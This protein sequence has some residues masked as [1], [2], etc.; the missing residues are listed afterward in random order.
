VKNFVT[1]HC[2][3]RSLDSASTP[4]QFAKRELELE[5]GHIVVTDH[6]TLEATRVVYDLTK[7]KRFGALKPI[8]G[9]EGYFRDDNCEILT[10]AGV[11][12]NKK[13]N[14]V[15]HLKYM[16]LTMHALDSQAYFALTRILSNADLRAEKHGSERKPLF[17]WK[18]LEE[19]GSFN[20]TVTSGCL[21]GMVSR[22]LLQH[23]DPRSA[24]R[25]YERL[26]GAFKPG[27]FYVEVFPHAC[28]RN[29]E[30][31]VIVTDEQGKE[32]R[33]PKW[34]KLKTLG[35]ELKAE[36]LASEVSV[37]KK[38]ALVKHLAIM[39]VMENR[40]WKALEAPVVIQSVLLKEG[41]VYNECRSWCPDGDVQRG[42]NE[43]LIELARRYKDPVLVSDDSHFA[44][45]KEKVAQDIRLAQQGDWRFA[46]SHHRFSSEEAWEYFRERQKIPQSQFESWVENTHAWADR[47]SEFKFEKRKVLPTGFYPQDTLRHTMHLIQKHGRM[48]WK[49]K[50][51]VDRLQTEIQL[52]HKNG[53]VDLLPYW[54]PDEEVVR[55][56]AKLGL[57]TGPGRGSAAGVLLTYLL[58]IT[59]IDPL[60]YK[61][62]LDRFITPDRIESGKYPDIDQD[63]PTREPLVGPDENSGWLK[64]RFGDCVAQMS[65]DTT[66]KLKSAIKDTFRALGKLGPDIEAFC[67]ALPNPPQGINDRD[68]VFGYKNSD[69]EWEQGLVETSKPLQD[70]MAKYPSEWETVSL[71]LGL[72]RQKSR[73]ACGFVISDEPIQ[74]F[75]PL[76]TVGGVRVTS[77]TAAAVEAAGGLKIDW[78]VVNSLNDIG[79]AL[80]L[81]RATE[82]YRQNMAPV[83]VD[84]DGIGY[85]IVDGKKVYEAAALP[86]MGKW[87]DI[88]NL[89]EDPAVFRD[90]C[91]GKVETVFQLDAGAARQGLRHFAPSGDKLPLD[92]IE[93][94][95]AFT[96]LD[97]PGGLNS[98]VTDGSTKHNMLV[99]YARRAR[100]L[101]SVGALPVLDAMLPETMGVLVYQ[102]QL[103]YVFQQAGGTTAL[104]SNAFRNRVSKKKMVEID[105]VDKP[106]FMKGAVERIGQQQAEK[107]WENM[108]EFANYGFNKSHAVCYMAISY[109][110]AFLKHYYPL[111]WWTAVLSNA[112]RGD[113]DGKFW[114][115]C[116]HL[117]D[118]PD[119]QLSKKEFVIQ[120]G[121]IRAPLSLLYGLGE[122][123]H[124]QL[125][126]GA[127]YTSIEGFLRSIQD[128]R[129]KNA[130]PKT[131]KV[132]GVEVPD[133][134]TVNGVSV[135]KMKLATTALNKTD[136]CNLIVSGAMDSLFP[137]TNA[138]GQPIDIV[139]RLEMYEQAA[140]RVSG[141]RVMGTAATKFNLHSALTRFQLRKKV[142]PAY[143]AIIK[144]MVVEETGFKNNSV[145]FNGQQW[146][147][148]NGAEFERIAAGELLPPGD[149]SIALPAYVVEQRNFTYKKDGADKTACELVLDVDGIRTSYVKWP[150]KSGLP[151]SFK[152]QLGGAVVLCFFSRSYGHDTFF[153][154]DV[155]VVKEPLGTEENNEES[156]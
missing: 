51:M 127:P 112:N 131:K 76:T 7:E 100:G 86:F 99:E 139:D 80:Q 97:R 143:S 66:M 77:F 84:E 136:I 147:M 33:F 19:L 129:L 25:Y 61:L 18:N 9:L 60:K 154:Q 81:V 96:A 46:N 116:G 75:I 138:I 68:Y 85:V 102:E 152:K 13:G 67:K 3:I 126:A 34:K 8:L 109:A 53:T 151:E 122:K 72:A 87:L 120:N 45:A 90:I 124:E 123:A 153:F 11:Q 4:E 31:A 43:F 155:L 36:A 82:S 15:D 107:L 88:W 94:L 150:G 93:D 1:P 62:S 117:V 38:A 103:Q 145:S 40:A 54:M 135:Q 69:G 78:L 57:L 121:R 70:F 156:P 144:D 105:K 89:P 110:T 14:F 142:L 114:R 47:F 12:K 17:D 106:L 74:N 79:R 141:K 119:I 134:Q 42:C 125:L 23:N 118:L 2:H 133:V 148:V 146:S 95:A 52:L 26:R 128:W 140:S 91:E 108:K 130:K 41:W 115:Y 22:H 73:H 137:A 149:I 111:E 49:N 104:E 39:E 29:W 21:I 24:V 5:T 59:H 27:N 71:L 56:Y 101:T 16:H 28:E 20:M 35:G 98:Y 113:I 30:S 64:E 83:S 132:D 44:H 63:L 65:T 6:G 58:G 48:D 92:S 37:N 32:H 10:S 55:L 50:E